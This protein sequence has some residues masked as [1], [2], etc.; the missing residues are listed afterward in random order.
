LYEMR[1]SGC[2]RISVGVESA[3]D[4]ILKNIKK[5]LSL[6]RLFEVT[7]AA[8]KFGIQIR[9][10]MMVGN[11][12]ETQETFQ[13]SLDFINRAK[14][15]QFVFSQLHLY[16]GTEEF[17]IFEKQGFVSPE[18]F[19][20]RDF[21][22]LTCFAGR[23]DDEKRIRKSLS[24]MAGVQNFRQYGVE[25]YQAVSARLPE[26]HLLHV[27]LCRAYLREGNPD[28]AERHLH[29]AVELG[30]FLPGLVDN[31]H[32]CIDAARN[33]FEGVKF[34]LDQAFACYPYQ[35]VIENQERF[36]S[37]LSGRGGTQNN[38]PLK[39]AAGDDFESTNIC[40]QPEFPGEY[41]GIYFKAA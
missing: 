16:P 41:A 7:Q 36:E 4:I 33:D 39:L 22:C 20:T 35:V 6:D 24:T 23:R 40:I 13:Q 25:E 31:L 10:Y 11:R 29:R 9:Y 17:D 12:G 8:K 32:A 19:F 30:Y 14:P 18:M 27:D 1:R 34:D 28:A 15:N 2:E 37:W 38:T 21:F 5:R 3:S 26:M